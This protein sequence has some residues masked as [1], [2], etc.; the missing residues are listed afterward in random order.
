MVSGILHLISRLQ[1]P[2]QVIA[3][4]GALRLKE[5]LPSLG[6]PIKMIKVANCR[7]FCNSPPFLF[8]DQTGIAFVYR[9]S[10]PGEEWKQI[11]ELTPSRSNVNSQFGYAVDISG[12]RVIVAAPYYNSGVKLWAGASSIFE[13]VGGVWKETSFLVANEEKSSSVCGLSVV[14]DGDRV[15]AGCWTDSKETT[16]TNFA[17]SV[18]VFTRDAT[19]N[20]WKETSHLT[21]SDA[22]AG[23][24]FGSAIA[25]KGNVLVVTAYG[26]TS[27]KA[28][29]TGAAYVFLSDNK[30]EWKEVT[31]LIPSVD[32]IFISAGNYYYYGMS[33]ALTEESLIVGAYG[34]A[35]NYYGDYSG[36]AYVYDYDSTGMVWT[37]RSKLRRSI[38]IPY[39]RVAHTVVADGKNV[40]LA[41]DGI[42]F[43]GVN[44]AGKSI[45]I[46]WLSNYN[47][48]WY[49]YN[50]CCVIL[51][52]VREPRHTRTLTQI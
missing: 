7:Y 26:V 14:L 49:M 3:L 23:D 36:A 10:A 17:G 40:L 12:G 33:A 9:R 16:A 21:A 42:D 43:N 25:V 51:Y 39:D 20:T 1:Q 30:G 27:T 35:W 45:T 29:Y 47:D 32:E 34:D 22:T 8:F 4:D 31:K 37:L 44:E 6:L 2:N 50:R 52:L 46:C 24:F 48:F 13:E 38:P 5:I 18:I 41:G 11:A 28:D 19:S 15:F